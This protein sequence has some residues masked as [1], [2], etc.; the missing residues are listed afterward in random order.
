MAEERLETA[1]SPLLSLAF[2]LSPSVAFPTHSLARFSDVGVGD[3]KGVAVFAMRAVNRRIARAID[4]L[5]KRGRSVKVGRLY[6]PTMRARHASLASRIGIV[7]K[8]IDR[9]SR[10]NRTYPMFVRPSVSL[11][12]AIGSTACPELPITKLADI[13]LPLKATVFKALSFGK[14]ADLGINADGSFIDS[15]SGSSLQPSTVMGP[16]PT[17]CVNRLFASFYGANVHRAKYTKSFDIGG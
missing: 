9:T 3:I 11:T 14:K 8:M 16:A 17:S 4:V 2:P 13:A 5:C 7:A 1:T 6:A 12:D 15:F 10:R